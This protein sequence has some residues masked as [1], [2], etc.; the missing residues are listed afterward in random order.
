MIGVGVNGGWCKE[1]IQE[2]SLSYLLL[3]NLF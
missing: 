2:G 3:G 1:G